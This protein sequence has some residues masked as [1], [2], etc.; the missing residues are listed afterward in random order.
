MRI[1]DV[2]RVGGKHVAL[3]IGTA[4]GYSVDGPAPTPEKMHSELH[5]RFLRDIHT[6]W[7][8]AHHAEV[9]SEGR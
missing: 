7:V 2:V 1:G 6:R 9:L 8:L 5:L 4:H 3:V